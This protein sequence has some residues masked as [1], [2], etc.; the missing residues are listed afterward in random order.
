LSDETKKAFKEFLEI[1][2]KDDPFWG[3]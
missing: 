1:K 3:K 2:R